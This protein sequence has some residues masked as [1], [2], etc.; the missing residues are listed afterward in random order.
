MPRKKAGGIASSR[1]DND[2]F[3]NFFNKTNNAH[4]IA[5]FKQFV[6]NRYSENE[7]KLRSSNPSEVEEAKR[8]FENRPKN[9]ANYNRLVNMI[10]NYY[11]GGSAKVKSSGASAWDKYLRQDLQDYI[12]YRVNKELESKAKGFGNNEIAFNPAGRLEGLY[13]KKE[14]EELGLANDYDYR[15]RYS[16]G[17][18]VEEDGKIIGNGFD[19]YIKALSNYIADV[20]VS[21]ILVCTKEIHVAKSSK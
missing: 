8:F 6:K 11:S 15:V 19:M 10:V 14:Y 13:T 12:Q 3:E 21:I 9:F 17:T 4:N 7:M 1:D 16:A 18:L 2:C 20:P 5:D